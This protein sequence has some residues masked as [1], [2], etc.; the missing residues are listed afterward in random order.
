MIAHSNHFL[1]VHRQAALF[2]DHC[3]LF[4]GGGAVDVHGLHSCCR[5]NIG[6]DEGWFDWL[7]NTP[8]FDNRV[9]QKC[10][11]NSIEVML[12]ERAV[13]HESFAACHSVKRNA[14]AC[15]KPNQFVGHCIGYARVQRSFDDIRIGL[16]Q[17]VPF[18]ALQQGVDKQVVEER[19]RVIVD[20]SM[21]K[22]KIRY[23]DFGNASNAQFACRL[24]KCNCPWVDAPSGDT[25]VLGSQN[26]SQTACH[27]ETIVD[28]EKW[29]GCFI[30]KVKLW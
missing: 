14:H 22:D 12:T 29:S 20:L 19:T 24:S 4:V 16:Y 23:G 18:A 13:N 11:N 6:V 10:G 3:K 28:N 26:W 5:V 27:D 8:A 15:C 17:C 21:E 25:Q 1:G 9:G 30:Q 7:I 2:I